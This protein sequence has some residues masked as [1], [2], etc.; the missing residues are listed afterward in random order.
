MHRCGYWPCEKQ[1]EDRF[2]MCGPDWAMVPLELQTNVY[3]AYE[4]RGGKPSSPL[5]EDYTEACEAAA[6]AVHARRLWGRTGGIRREGQEYVVLKGAEVLGRS[7]KSY[8]QAFLEYARRV[9]DELKEHLRR[10]V[11]DHI[12][13]DAQKKALQAAHY[14][15][16]KHGMWGL[17]ERGREEAARHGLL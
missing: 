8:R 11:V 17:T 3:R 9:E 4:R 10:F 12:V 2:L 13:S 5:T 14:I 15:N 6:A 1:V 7:V 16:Y